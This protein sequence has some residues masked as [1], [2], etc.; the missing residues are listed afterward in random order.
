VPDDARRY[1]MVPEVPPVGRFALSN[2]GP[3]NNPMSEP[4]P[5]STSN[6][7]PNPGNMSYPQPTFELSL[8]AYLMSYPYHKPDPNPMPTIHP[9]PYP[10]TAPYPYPGISLINMPQSE[11]PGLSTYHWGLITFNQC[12]VSGYAPDP[13]LTSNSC[14]TVLD[15]IHRC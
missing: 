8:M 3:D 13:R 10:M 14:P 2:A 15:D 6:P 1:T 12:P 5:N 4:F 11:I 9:T 7:Y